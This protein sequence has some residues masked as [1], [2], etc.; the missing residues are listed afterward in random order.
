MKLTVLGPGCWGLTIAKLLN[1]NFDEICGTWER[2]A[3]IVYPGGASK[4]KEKGHQEIGKMKSEWA[5]N[6]GKHINVEKNLSPSFIE[7]KNLE[8]EIT[9]STVKK[10]LQA[11][12]KVNEPVEETEQEVL[13][14]PVVE[15]VEVQE[16]ESVEV[17]EAEV[18]EDKE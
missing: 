3:D 6:I 18:V 11:R 12:V 9:K 8:I 5:V 10:V 15:E 13:E 1:N 17:V 2:L 16:A 4:L 14:E 7:F